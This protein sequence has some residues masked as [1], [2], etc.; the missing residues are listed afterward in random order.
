VKDVAHSG[1]IRQS[2]GALFVKIIKQYANDKNINLGFK[3]QNLTAY[4]S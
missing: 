3:Q 4:K 1:K 2:R